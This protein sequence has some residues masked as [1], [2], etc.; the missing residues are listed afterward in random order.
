[1]SFTPWHDSTHPHAPGLILF[2]SHFTSLYAPPRV[3]FVSF[4]LPPPRARFGPFQLPTIS[5][6]LFSRFRIP[7]DDV[8]VNWSS[9]QA[10]C[11][12]R[13]QPVTKRSEI[14]DWD[15]SPR[16]HT[17]AWLR[18]FFNHTLLQVLVLFLVS[19]FKK[20]CPPP[21]KLPCPGYRDRTDLPS[22]SPRDGHNEVSEYFGQIN[23]R[24][25]VG[26]RRT[27]DN[28]DMPLN[29]YLAL[30]WSLHNK[31]WFD[32]TVDQLPDLFHTTQKVKTQQN[33]LPPGQRCLCL[34]LFDKARA[35]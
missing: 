9:V 24:L 2:N 31:S 35:K 22:W 20:E 19:S 21:K 11:L 7:T 33:L 28:P 18:R 3:R 34:L 14:L 5:A 30:V 26:F 25:N 17:R 4:Q 32:W 8:T 16:P 27:V 1:M 15:P 29:L 12:V 23:I 10:V 13:V 6:T